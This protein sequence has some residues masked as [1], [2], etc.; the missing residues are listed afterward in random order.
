MPLFRSSF[1]LYLFPELI[2]GFYFY[3]HYVYVGEKEEMRYCEKQRS[4]ACRWDRQ[5][6]MKQS[7]EEKSHNQYK[8]D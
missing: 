7:S 2:P 6:C 8:L 1:V 5:V 3:F 4:E